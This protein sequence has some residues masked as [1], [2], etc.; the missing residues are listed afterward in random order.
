[1]T[2]PTQQQVAVPAGV[3]AVTTYGSIRGETASCLMEMRSSAEKAGLQNVGWATVPGALVDKARN[4]AVRVMLNSFRHPPPD[5]PS[6]AQWILFVDGDMVFAP[7]ALQRILGTAYGTHPWADVVGGYCTLKG[8]P[9]LPTID[10]GTGTWESHFPGRGVL[11]VIRTGAA[12]LLCKRNVFDR[13]PAPWF[14]LRVPARPLDF[15]AEVDNW[16]RMKMNGQNPFI[17][18]PGK[19][20]EKLMEHATAD[21]SAQPGVFVPAEVG[22]D[23]GFCDRAKAAGM[24][25]IVDTNIEIKHLETVA[26]GWTDHKKAVEKLETQWLQCVGVG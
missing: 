16:A 4:D 25:I 18:L 2:T 21:P 5:G 19:P 7:D 11:E 3:V 10:T 24:R 9:A 14:H 1:M 20:W 23:S 13:L 22:E 8:E 26:R 12:F 17:G 15:M 6:Q